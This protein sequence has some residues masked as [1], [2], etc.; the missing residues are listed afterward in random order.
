VGARTA[1]QIDETAAAGD[2]DLPPE[3]VDE[4]SDLLAWREAA[5]SA[6]A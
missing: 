6:A 4:I 2:V 3:D 5:I 1:D